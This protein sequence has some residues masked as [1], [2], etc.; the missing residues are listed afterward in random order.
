VTLVRTRRVV[1]LSGLVVLAAV[2]I[3]LAVVGGPDTGR[4]DR[5]DAARL[6]ALR[7]IAGALAC[8]AASGSEP[9]APITLAEVSPACLDSTTARRLLD[10]QTGNPYRIDYPAPDRARVCADFEATMSEARIAGW[11]PFDA[12]TGCVS[13]NTGRD[14]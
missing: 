5:R 3:G 1:I 12:S 13:I 10:P 14:R 4:R 9:A 7:Q 6:D 2:V 8:H 11:P